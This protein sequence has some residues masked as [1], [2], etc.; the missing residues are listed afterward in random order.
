MLGLGAMCSVTKTA[1]TG[2]VGSA[3][4]ITRNSDWLISMIIF[5]RLSV[6]FASAEQG[7]FLW[8]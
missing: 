7:I 1:R 6:L 4:D 2:A 5:H 3:K 8:A